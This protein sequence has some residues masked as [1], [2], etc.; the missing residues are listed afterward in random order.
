MKSIGFACLELAAAW[1]DTGHML[2]AEIAKAQLTAREVSVVEDILRTWTDDFPGMSG[3]VTSAVWPDHI[4]CSNTNGP[5]C[6]GLAASSLH[7]FDAWHY[8]DVTFNPDDVQVRDQTAFGNPSAVWAL[9]QAMRTFHASQ[10]KFALNFAMRFA[11]HL[12]GDIHQPL[13]AAQGF[14]ADPR[15]GHLA[16]DR[17]GNLIR[18]HSNWSTLTNLHAFWDSAGG[19]YLDNWPFT[20]RQEG[21]LQRNASDILAEFPR[22]SLQEYNALEM[23][24]Y[25]MPSDCSS[26]FKRW[27]QQNHLLAVQDAY[28]GVRADAV[29][30]D[31]YAATV[32]RVSRRQL[33]L[34]GYRLADSLRAVIPHLQ[35]PPPAASATSLFERT[36][37]SMFGPA[38]QVLSVVCLLQFF[39]LIILMAILC[40]K[41]LGKWRMDEQESLLL[42][43]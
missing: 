6:R 32:R 4:K 40:H 19:L 27:I 20:L 38:Q 29:V 36:D 22:T 14:F 13:H 41:R 15:F 9:T 7:Q 5:K 11:L 2:V 30:S 12:V 17:G 18:I 24:C 31:D 34:A 26:V 43:V 35:L 39:F 8:S 37:G 23:S 1:T 10:S 21:L 42:R 25:A 28:R 3:F 16:G 33:A